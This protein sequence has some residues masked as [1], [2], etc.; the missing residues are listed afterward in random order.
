MCVKRLQKSQW[1]WKSRWKISCFNKFPASLSSQS[2]QPQFT[3]FAQ[4]KTL[5][6][7]H[8]GWISTNYYPTELFFSFFAHLICHIIRIEFQIEYSSLLQSV[9]D[10][11]KRLECSSWIA[12]I[13][14][15]SQCWREVKWNE[16]EVERDLIA[17]ERDTRY[18]R[19]FPTQNNRGNRFNLSGYSEPYQIQ[20]NHQLY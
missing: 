5:N 14:N 12:S 2:C 1:N 18:S 13:W 16:S 15:S 6:I 19:A 4:C 20:L 3:L 9:L 7:A 11:S 8:R 17:C 10:G